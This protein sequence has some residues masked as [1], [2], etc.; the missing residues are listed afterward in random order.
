MPRI[1]SITGHTMQAATRILERYL[2]MTPALLRA[3]M[4]AFENA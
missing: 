3:A 2:S 4:T 1:V